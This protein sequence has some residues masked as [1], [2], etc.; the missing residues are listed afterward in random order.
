M[1]AVDARTWADLE[2]AIRHQ[3]SML[4]LDAVPDKPGV[5]AWYRNAQRMYVGKADSLRDRVYGN[6]LGQSK[7][8]TGSA[9]RRNVAEYLGFG[10][11]A[12]IKKRE[13]KL[14]ADQL[15]AIRAWILSCEVSW[16]TCATKAA[17][18]KLETKLKVEFK[19]PLTKR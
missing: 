15:I 7:A 6:H 4:V 12:A 10:S 18:I 19:P 16:L 3:P 2:G 11:S 13:I 8:P 9:F 1:A 14:T 17:A 5:Y